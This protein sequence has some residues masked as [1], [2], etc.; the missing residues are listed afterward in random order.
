MQNIGLKA[1]KFGGLFY[2]GCA[3]AVVNLDTKE[4]SKLHW[5]QKYFDVSY[6]TAVLWKNTIIMPRASFS[7]ARLDLSGSEMTD[8][9]TSGFDPDPK[10]PSLGK[11]LPSVNSN[12][13]FVYN[14]RFFC[15]MPERGEMV[16]VCTKPIKVRYGKAEDDQAKDWTNYCEAISLTGNTEDFTEKNFA[17]TGANLLSQCGAH[18]LHGAKEIWVCPNLK[19]AE[20]YRITDIDKNSWSVERIAGTGILTPGGAGTYGRFVVFEIHNTKIGM[21]I[22]STSEPIEVIRLK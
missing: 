1:P 14:S 10:T 19:A 5:N 17:D 13:A 3:K 15:D 8:W 12:A 22:S 11:T 20:L 4:Y 18:Y 16:S 7:Y 2:P 6:I 9:Q 21:R